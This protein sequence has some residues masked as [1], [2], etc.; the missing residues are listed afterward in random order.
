MLSQVTIQSGRRS[1]AMT[2]EMLLAQRNT[3]VMARITIPDLPPVA[4][5]PQG[6]L[7]DILGMGGRSFS[8]ASRRWKT[9]C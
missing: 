4:D 8:L 7:D 5:I 1:A 9:A 3:Q 2:T 6:E